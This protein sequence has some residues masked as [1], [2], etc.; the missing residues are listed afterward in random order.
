MTDIARIVHQLG[1]IA[2]KQQLVARGARDLDLTRA[3][4]SGA[5][6]R[7]RQGWYTTL[8]SE[9]LR[10]RAVRVGGR[11]TGLSAVHALGG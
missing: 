2:Q 1:G 9:D 6:D 7:A 3:F 8:P 11:L 10:V 4:R 5:V